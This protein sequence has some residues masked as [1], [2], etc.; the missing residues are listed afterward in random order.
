MATDRR[1]SLPASEAD[2]SRVAIDG[3][4][5][6]TAGKRPYKVIT[7]E[8]G[9]MIPEVIDAQ[10]R[11]M[12]T[13]TDEG[14]IGWTSVLGRFPALTDWTMRVADMDRDGVDTQVLL[15][16][17]P[18]IQIFGADEAT[19][20]A[21]LTNDRATDEAVRKYPGRFALLAAVAPQDA[22]AA[23]R[24]L[25]RAVTKLGAKGG[26]INGH[27]KGEYLDEDK[28]MPIFEAAESL[29][30]PIYIHPR[31]PSPQ[32]LAPYQK[33]GLETAVWGFA[34]EVSLHVLRMIWA[35]VF[36]RYPKLKIVIGH[37]GEN[38]PFALDRL[39]TT[40]RNSLVFPPKSSLQ[41]P[42]A[43]KRPPSEYFR[44]NIYCT[45]SGINWAPT[46]N[47]MQQVLGADRVLFAVDYPFTKQGW[48]IERAEQAPM[49]DA[50]RK[51][52]F[53]CNA[54]KVFKLA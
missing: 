44:D 27:T 23:A 47:F 37:A 22:E 19:A 39:D 32:M 4:A 8:E 31:E 30:V 49:S 29:D 3:S 9:F 25:E 40:Y 14:G 48:E 51:L 17:G 33:W 1:S 28:F 6:R 34:A 16:A 15:I 54:E 36:D 46:I 2:T 5:G 50:D 43:A 13:A 7:V 45:T 18:A 38:L 24:E 52:F 26:V 41:Q 11:Y 42:M 53:Q 21:R 12:Q 35:G 20:L 10:A